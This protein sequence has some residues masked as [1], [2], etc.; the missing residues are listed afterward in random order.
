MGEKGGGLYGA[1]GGPG[2]RDATRARRRKKQAGF[3]FRPVRVRPRHTDGWAR[4]LRPAPLAFTEM[5]VEFVGRARDPTA[6]AELERAS[7]AGRARLLICSVLRGKDAGVRS[8]VGASTRS[9]KVWSWRV[10]AVS[11]SLPVN[12]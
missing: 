7:P 10:L 2:P 11:F 5:G 8:K 12:L 1:K 9:K 6:A 4:R 3:G